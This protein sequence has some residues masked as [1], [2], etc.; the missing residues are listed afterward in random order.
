ML[1]QS[2]YRR[3][4]PLGLILLVAM[5][6]PA[7]AH[8]YWIEPTQFRLEAGANIVAHLKLGQTFKGEVYP[9]IPQLAKEAWLIDANGRRAT[10]SRIGAIPAFS[11]GAGPPGLHIVTYHSTPSRLSYSEPGKFADFLA[12]EGLEWAGAEHRAR[13]LPETGFDE[14]FTRCAKALVHSGGGGGDD[15]AIGMPLELVARTSPYALPADAATLP[16]VLLWQG[17]P[18]ADAQIKVF[19]R[20]GEVTVTTVRTGPDGAAS[21][22]LDDGGTFLLNAVHL[23]PWDEQPDDAWHSYWASLTFEIGAD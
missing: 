6:S 5:M 9:F 19:R 2:R 4:G 13:G 3:L 14:A 7:W 17:A 18:L 15:K 22:P 11:E 16:V 20:Q 12:A 21:I 23:I 8:E 1:V 10:T